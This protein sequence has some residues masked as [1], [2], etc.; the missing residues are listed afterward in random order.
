MQEEKWVTGA[1]IAEITS[2]PAAT[3]S[4]YTKTHSLH[5]PVR[6][7][8]RNVYYRVP[9]AVE[10][11]KEIRELYNAG[12]NSDQVEQL[13]ADRYETVIEVVQDSQNQNLEMTATQAFAAMAEQVKEMKE[14]MKELKAGQKKLEEHIKTRD[15]QLMQGLR[16][17]QE[18]QQQQLQLQQQRKGA[19]W[20]RIFRK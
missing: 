1:E 5:L 12:K 15:Q 7:E 18:R 10:I 8:G 17:I 20:N 19:F 13:L 9:K 16:N 6:R 2:I 3:I 11:I 4:R 14:E